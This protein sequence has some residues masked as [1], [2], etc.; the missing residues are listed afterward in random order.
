MKMILKY[1]S[2]KKINE[3]LN[4]LFRDEYDKKMLYFYKND[5]HKIDWL[6]L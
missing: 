1:K 6:N 3:K 5:K 4:I 2:E